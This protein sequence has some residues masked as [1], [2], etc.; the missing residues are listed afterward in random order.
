M[1]FKISYLGRPHDIQTEESEEVNFK[2]NIQSQILRSGFL[3]KSIMDFNK[4]KNSETTHDPPFYSLPE[5]TPTQK[6]IEDSRIKKKSEISTEPKKKQSLLFKIDFDANPPLGDDSGLTNRLPIGN[7][8]ELAEKHREVG[9]KG[10]VGEELSFERN[11]ELFKRE[12]AEFLEKMKKVNFLEVGV[13]DGKEKTV[14]EKNIEMNLEKAME[15]RKEE[16]K[17]FESF[18]S[19]DNKIDNFS[20]CTQK[21][22]TLF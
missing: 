1:Q 15:D 7:L 18:F 17:N 4:R 11:L 13:E 21:I 16:N 5:I 9:G 12:E 8:E 10:E 22:L 20:S 19:V 6:L 2:S 14:R 3:N